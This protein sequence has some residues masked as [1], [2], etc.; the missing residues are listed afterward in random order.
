MRKVVYLLIMSVSVIMQ[1]KLAG[2]YLNCCE[3]PY[4]GRIIYRERLKSSFSKIDLNSTDSILKVL[5]HPLPRTCYHSGKTHEYAEEQIN[6]LIKQLINIKAD[7]NAVNPSCRTPLHIAAHSN[8]ES[9]IST[10]LKANANPNL[11]DKC[12]WTPLDYCRNFKTAKHLIALGARRYTIPREFG[13]KIIDKISLELIYEIINECGNEPL[14][15]QLHP[16]SVLINLLFYSIQA[17]RLDFVCKLLALE[18][19]L[20][21]K[22]GDGIKPIH[23]AIGSNN[24]GIFRALL[25]AGANVTYAE[26]LNKAD[27]INCIN[28]Y[29]YA[30]ALNLQEIAGIP[31]PLGKLIGHYVYG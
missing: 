31:I 15:D 13:S 29:I 21:I 30:I 19:E 16:N 6:G 28:Q 1:I 25:K 18:L 23:F 12:G 11:M 22:S 26:T 24:C 4:R 14:I 7:I 10:L 2:F 5:L 17:K 9:V 8:Y 27:L 3:D 20:E